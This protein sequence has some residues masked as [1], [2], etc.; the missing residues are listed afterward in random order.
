MVL[1]E[2]LIAIIEIL[3][4]DLADLAHLGDLNDRWWLNAVSCLLHGSGR[5]KRKLRRGLAFRVH[6]RWK[7]IQVLISGSWS[8]WAVISTSY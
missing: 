8:V 7:E 3:L 4:A 1:K 6:A 5:Y 2:P